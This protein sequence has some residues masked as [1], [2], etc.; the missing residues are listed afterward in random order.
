MLHIF[1]ILPC[2]K[3]RFEVIDRLKARARGVCR[4]VFDRVLV[5]ALA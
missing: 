5:M 4:A 3:H 2:S 1:D